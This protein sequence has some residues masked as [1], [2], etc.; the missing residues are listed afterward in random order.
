MTNEKESQ[1]M[2]KNKRGVREL[3]PT[4]GPESDTEKGDMSKPLEYGRV[5]KYVIIQ[6]RFHSLPKKT[7][8]SLPF[9]K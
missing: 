9:L 8:I 7:V 6:P 5:L 2:F 1:E 4:Q 3:R